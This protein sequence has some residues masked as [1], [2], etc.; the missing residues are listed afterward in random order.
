VFSRPG[1]ID[2]A[3]STGARLKLG[4]GGGFFSE[5]NRLFQSTSYNIVGIYSFLVS[6]LFSM[7]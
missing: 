4:I 6:S 5:K 7:L 3:G 2:E 1:D